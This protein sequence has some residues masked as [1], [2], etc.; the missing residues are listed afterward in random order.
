M[1]RKPRKEQLTLIYGFFLDRSGS[2]A[3]IRQS[4]IDGYNEWLNGLQ[5]DARENPDNPHL[6]CFHQFD[7][8]NPN[9]RIYEFRDVLELQPLK[10][11]QPRGMTPLYDGACQAI[12]AVQLGRAG[13]PGKSAVLA[14][15]MT[16]GLENASK[17]ETKD[18]LRVL[19]TEMEKEN[20][21]F[22]YMAAN[23]DAMT[24]A[25]KF[26]T[27]SSISNTATWQADEAGVQVLFSNANNATQRYSSGIRRMSMAGAASLTMDA[28]WEGTTSDATGGNT[29]STTADPKGI[30]NPNAA[31]IAVVPT[32]K[33]ADVVILPPG[34]RRKV[35]TQKKS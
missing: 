11:F 1:P 4:V 20:W 9:E 29:Y 5:V 28:I 12:R 6:L 7:G 32:I 15:I 23:Q 10:Y 16:D 27:R 31:P 17:T 26:G 35:R 21:T 8:Q 2:M 24:E 22:S 34:A 25:T 13:I 18:S 33:E 3:T 14:M 30:V 19:M